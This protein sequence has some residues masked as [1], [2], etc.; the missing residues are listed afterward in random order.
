MPGEESCAKAPD[1]GSPELSPL[2]LKRVSEYIMTL[3]VPA[4]RGVT[5]ESVRHGE[6][7]FREMKCNAC[8]ITEFTTGEEPGHPELSGQVI[9]PYTDLLLHDMG[10]GLADG[11]P[12]F[13]ASGREWRTPPLW[14]IGL[15]KTVNGHTCFL[16][17]GRARDVQEA[18]LW[19]GG[20]A[21]PAKESYRKL[22]WLDRQAV[23][24]FL[25]SL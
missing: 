18:I 17:D 25:D 13:E 5:N 11:R 23:L 6:A 15:T 9:H 8:H 1:G 16:H 7:L 3:A 21:E 14:G 19:H 2:K 4:R 10:E 20:E 12:D 22:S 24:S